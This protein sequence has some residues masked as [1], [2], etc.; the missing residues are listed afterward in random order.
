MSS[1]FMVQTWGFLFFSA[2]RLVCK[3]LFLLH[4]A[5]IHK[6]G[7]QI[8]PRRAATHGAQ[9]QDQRDGIAQQAG[10][11]ATAISVMPITTKVMPPMRWVRCQLCSSFS[12][13]GVRQPKV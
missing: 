10:Q 8:D 12:A 7:I 2:L 9:Q 3:V 5:N 13:Q 11:K 4:L 6:I 1:T